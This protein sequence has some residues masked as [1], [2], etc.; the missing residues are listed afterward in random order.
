MK[1]PQLT[2]HLKCKFP[3]KI[4]TSTNMPILTT[5]IQQYRGSSSGNQAGNRSE[6]SSR[7]EKKK[8]IFIDNKSL[9]IENHEEP[10]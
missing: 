6:K 8:T 5:A 3:P 7:L 2:T 9:D 4:R 10:N 1:N